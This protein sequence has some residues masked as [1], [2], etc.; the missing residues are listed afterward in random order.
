MFPLRA[1]SHRFSFDFFNFKKNA[2]GEWR[3]IQNEE[4]HIL[5]HSPYSARVTKPRRLRRA[6]H[7][8]RMEEGRSSFQNFNR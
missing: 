6:G 4:L 5:Y 2:N 1:V 8:V 3:R 7:V